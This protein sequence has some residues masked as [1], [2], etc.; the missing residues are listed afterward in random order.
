MTAGNRP[1]IGLRRQS[2]AGASA[3]EFA[4]VVP[5]LLVLLFGIFGFGKI[6]AQEL[7]LGNGARQAARFGVVPDRTCQEILDELQAN[8]GTIGMAG[9]SVTMSVR[10]GA[11]GATSSPRC[12][13]GSEE[14]CHESTSGDNLYV[15]ARFTSSLMIPLSPVGDPD[16][17]LAGVGVFRCEFS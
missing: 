3:V 8:A 9:T 17:H 2:E 14:P 5:L 11:T 7:A 12:A 16:F 15:E 6:F 10:L 1:K 4:L 13:D